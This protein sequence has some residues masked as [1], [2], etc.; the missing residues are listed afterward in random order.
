MASPI[1][2]TWV[3]A[4]SRSRWW[5]GKPGTLQSTG[6]L[7]V[8]HDWA[9]ELNWTELIRVQLHCFAC[10]SLVFPVPLLKR[11]SF[12][13]CISLVP[14]SKINWPY[15]PGFTSGLSI[16][17]HSPNGAGEDSWKYPLD[18]TEIKPF[19]PKGNRAWIFFR[20]TDAEAETP[21]LWPP[22]AKN[23]LIGKDPDAEKDWSQ[24]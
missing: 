2:W 17:L 10:G 14:L 22:D 11:L 20:R 13:R 16:L 6:S 3:W 12:L 1:W 9:T 5:I 7:Q 4:S 21:I 15:Y 19:N 24:E 18:N 8:R 23:W